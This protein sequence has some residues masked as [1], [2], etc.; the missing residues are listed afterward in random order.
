MRYVGGIFVKD[1]PNVWTWAVDAIEEHVLAAE[2]HVSGRRFKANAFRLLRQP[3]FRR[4][5]P[6][7]SPKDVQ[8]LHHLDASRLDLVFRRSQGKWISFNVQDGI[9][10]RHFPSRW[11]WQKEQ[12][13]RTRPA[14]IGTSPKMLH[15]DEKRMIS[16]EQYI[17]GR[18]VRVH[19]LDEGLR[20]W[21]QLWPSLGEVFQTRTVHRP[22]RLPAWIRQSRANDWLQRTRLLDV[23]EKAKETPVLHG[24]IHG[25]LQQSNMLV[26]KDRFYI[27]DW[28]DHFHMRPPL[29]DLLFYMFKH[30]LSVPLEDVVERAFSDF[31]WIEDGLPGALEPSAVEASFVAFTLMLVHRYQ[32]RKVRRREYLVKHLQA[33]LAEVTHRL[34][35]SPDA[36]VQLPAVLLELAEPEDDAA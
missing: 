6:L 27:I 34:L 4:C 22:V 25:D 1:D 17:P 29:Y 32:F 7:R 24:L 26:S 14:V 23:V 12:W 15:W 19:D 8:L 35:P 16:A 33:F 20:A 9:L 11:R 3:W 5:L 36:Y 13:I 31:Q 21:F 28:G 30:S 2:P 10:T 18:P